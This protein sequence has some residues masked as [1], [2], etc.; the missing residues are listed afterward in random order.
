M[1]L[2]V[3]LWKLPIIIF[4]TYISIEIIWVCLID[5]LCLDK[6]CDVSCSVLWV[7]HLIFVWLSLLDF[8]IPQI[9]KNLAL[10]YMQGISVLY[11]RKGLEA[12]LSGYQGLLCSAPL[13][14]TLLNHI[15]MLMMQIG[16]GLLNETGNFPKSC[17]FVR[18]LALAFQ[19]Y[20]FCFSRTTSK[21]LSARAP[22]LMRSTAYLSSHHGDTV[23]RKG[24]MRAPIWLQ[25]NQWTGPGISHSKGLIVLS[26]F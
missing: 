23:K 12:H 5:P 4:K 3:G 10:C 9:H 1:F 14:A 19:G 17:P 15:M 24:Y 22:V 20:C 11:K 16:K 26:S 25:L 7:S 2:G 18:R 13:Y 8:K 21:L 6:K